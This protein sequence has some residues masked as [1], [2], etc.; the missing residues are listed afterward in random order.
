MEELVVCRSFPPA[1]VG[2]LLGVRTTVSPV[3]QFHTFRA[4]GCFV[5]VLGFLNNRVS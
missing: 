5:G 4:R 2:S 1:V 3:C